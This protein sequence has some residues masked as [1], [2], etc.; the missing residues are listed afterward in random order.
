[1][2]KYIKLIIILISMLLISYQ[3]V[4]GDG[5]T[6]QDLIE[7]GKWYDN[8]Y[9]TYEGEAIGDIMRR[10]DYAWINVHDGSNAMGI[11]I[12]SSDVD[13]IKHT[14]TYKFTGDIVSIQG[15]FH[16]ACALH[17]GDMDIHATRMEIIKQGTRSFYLIPSSRI[18]LSIVL[19]I[20][21]LIL[22]GIYRR[23]KGDIKIN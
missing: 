9:I 3:V 23:S 19:S 18:F 12:N 10:G 17:G 7:Q 1:M 8:K 11:W 22:Y 15:I 6:S 16:R 14:G 13:I 4:L 5:V 20:L 2:Q 21:T